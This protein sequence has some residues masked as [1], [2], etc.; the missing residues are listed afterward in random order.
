MQIPP[1]F[2]GKQFQF[3]FTKTARGNSPHLPKIQNNCQAQPRIHKVNYFY[4][5]LSGQTTKAPQEGCVAIE[6]G[7]I[8]A[9]ASIVTEA[10]LKSGFVVVDVQLG[11]SGILKRC[12]M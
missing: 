6:D 4:H 5:V 2:Y 10:R 8:G 9:V 1:Y 11:R 12:L 3:E 7:L